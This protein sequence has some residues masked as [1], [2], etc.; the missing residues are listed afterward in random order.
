MWSGWRRLLVRWV[1]GW[2]HRLVCCAGSLGYLSESSHHRKIED[3][4]KIQ[5]NSPIFCIKSY[6]NYS[7]LNFIINRIYTNPSPSGVAL[8]QVSIPGCQKKLNGESA[9]PLLNWGWGQ[10]GDVACLWSSQALKT[11]FVSHF[12]RKLQS[13]PLRIPPRE[14]FSC[15]KLHIQPSKPDIVSIETDMIVLEDGWWGFNLLLCLTFPQNTEPTGKRAMGLVDWWHLYLCTSG[16][17]SLQQMLC[18]LIYNTVVIY[19]C[20]I[21][22][23]SLCK[24]WMSALYEERMWVA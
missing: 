17:G 18:I 10:L 3:F 22:N 16:P 23:V 1:E 14:F 19:S 2:G 12:M 6:K 4:P 11:V 13:N 24:F 9:S 5:S 8:C 21:S 7:A 15:H 20:Q